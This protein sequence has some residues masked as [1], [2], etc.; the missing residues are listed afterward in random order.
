LQYLREHPEYAR[1][2]A[3]QKFGLPST[4]GYTETPPP[5]DLLETLR[6]AQEVKT[7]L[8]DELGTQ[9]EG[10]LSG[11]ASIMHELPGIIPALQGMTGQMPEQQVEIQRAPPQ[12][13]LPP[14]TREQRLTEFAE[15]FL[16][17][18]PEAAAQELYQNRN[19]VEDVRSIIWRTV[20]ENDSFSVDDAINM[21]PLLDTMPKYQFLKPTVAKLTTD[22]G[23][24]WIALVLDEINKL[25]VQG[26]QAI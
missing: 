25:K 12:Q 10:T 23:K 20:T 9:G 17:L 7:M 1:E 21:I 14:V 4:E 6:T 5:P 11:I 18:P 24:Q 3:R 13:A 26:N 2:I 22:A 8:K 16:T 19:K 15:R